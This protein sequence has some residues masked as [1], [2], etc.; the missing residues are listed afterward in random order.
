MREREREW[1]WEREREREG[2][3]DRLRERG[4]WDRERERERERETKECLRLS[5]SA[6]KFFVEMRDPF[7]LSHVLILFYLQPQDWHFNSYN[8]S[9]KT[10]ICCCCCFK[11][12]IW[13]KPFNNA[14]IGLNVLK[15]L[16]FALLNN[17]SKLNLE[18]KNYFPIEV[19]SISITIISIYFQR[20]FNKHQKIYYSISHLI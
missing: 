14:Q 13:K 19:S 5:F 11:G 7:C 12:N 3:G 8:R 20:R 15:F 1:E 16:V 10:W 18:L 2:E 17:S 9:Q 4:E 6:N